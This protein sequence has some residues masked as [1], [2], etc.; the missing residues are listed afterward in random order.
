MW[1]PWRRSS[2]PSAKTSRKR[3]RAPSLSSRDQLL[4][5]P[6]LP[7]H[8]PLSPSLSP[9]LPL[10]LPLS[11]SL[12]LI[13]SLSLP[14]SEVTCC[15]RLLTAVSPGGNRCATG[16]CLS[17]RR[18]EARSLRFSP[19]SAYPADRPCPLSPYRMP[20]YA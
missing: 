18:P 14:L 15:Q 13:L 5:S 8:L 3:S 1:W 4:P 20:A 7:L 17:T 2:P 6:A 16:W 9:S 11:L 10:P 19:L 12:D